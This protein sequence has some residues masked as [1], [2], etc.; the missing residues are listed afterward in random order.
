MV[1]LTASLLNLDSFGH[2]IVVNYRGKDKYQTK[3]GLLC[4]VIVY[5]LIA[6]Y[7]ANL[8]SQFIS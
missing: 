7:A 8:V 3:L 4:T 2:Q 5:S 6:V 1:N